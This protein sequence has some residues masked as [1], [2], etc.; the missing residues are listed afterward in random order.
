MRLILFRHG[1]AGAPDPRRWPDDR[2]RPLTA[3]GEERTRRA[4][5]GLRRLEGEFPLILTSPLV[6]CA[7]SAE[8]LREA[9]G[10]RSGVEAIASLA[11]GGSWRQVLQRVA[12]ESP[13]ATIVLVGH[14]PQLGKLAGVLVFGAPAALP[15]KKA[16]ACALAFEDS[17]APGAG[18]LCWF[19]TPR[20]LVRLAPSRSKV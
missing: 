6:R 2:H 16:G 1:P 10:S 17:V 13:D 14:E 9:G 15:L 3:K 11:P 20:L 12:E 19:L 8:L 5:R 4:G 18:R 7:R